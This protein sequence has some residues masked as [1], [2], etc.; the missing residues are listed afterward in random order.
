VNTTTGQK[1]MENKNN[2]FDYEISPIKEAAIKF[3]V[4]IRD[5]GIGASL[6]FLLI[7]LIIVNAHSLHFLFGDGVLNW[8]FS[9]FSAIG[10]SFATISVLRK[11]VSPWMKYTFPL[12]DGALVY[13][14]FNIIEGIPVKPVMIILYAVF[15]IAI[16]MGL[17][18]INFFENSKLDAEKDMQREVESLKLVVKRLETSLTS[19]R[20]SLAS[21]KTT[22]SDTI[23]EMETYK[24][25]Y[26][27]TEKSRILKKKPENRTKTELE[28]LNQLENGTN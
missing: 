10:F 28:I 6:F 26:Y 14:G 9:I 7:M 1:G 19:D 27:A 12:F 24:K 15:T 23:A 22:L 21:V 5:G 18:F 4:F 11:P 8:F 3:D 13:L 16:L 2:Y 20:T 25:V 17:G